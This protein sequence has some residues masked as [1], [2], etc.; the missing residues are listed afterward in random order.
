MGKSMGKNG[1]KNIKGMTFMPPNYKKY[2]P[3][4]GYLTE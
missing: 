1:E 4:C 3:I 2:N